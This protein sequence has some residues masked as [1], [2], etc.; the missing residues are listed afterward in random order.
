MNTKTKLTLATALIAGL[1]SGS[2]LAN[3]HGET[4]KTDDHH[5]AAARPA[6]AKKAKAKHA[7]KHDKNECSG[8]EGCHGKEGH[9]EHKDEAH[10]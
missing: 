10:K 6:H 1:I 4:A 9:E 3:E 2:A 7:G 8:K 5:E